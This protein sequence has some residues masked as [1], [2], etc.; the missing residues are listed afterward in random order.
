MSAKDAKKQAEKAILVVDI[1]NTTTKFGIAEGGELLSTWE[2]TTSRAQTADEAW[3]LLAGYLNFKPAASMGSEVPWPQ[4]G[5][6]SSVVPSLTSAWTQATARLTG[7]RPLVVGPGLKTSLKMDFNDPAEVGSDRVADMVAAR[8][9]YGFPVVVVD[10]G[11]STNIEVMNDRGEFCGGI[12]AP[13]LHVSAAALSSKAARLPVV[14]IKAPASIVGKS[15]RE[16][17]QSGIIMGEIARI[18]GLID[19]VWR[20]LGYE[21]SIVMYGPDAEAIGALM[22]HD[23]TVDQGLTL[24]G[25]V[26]LYQH[27]RK[28]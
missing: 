17:M 3:F 15:T 21:T 27:N 22:A 13:G 16:A 24:Y 26:W 12:I 11:T 7:R 1:G 25:L 18:D 4:D 9:R 8:E 2:I 6:I 5:I 20:E 14:E 19:M 23:V 28:K 10:L